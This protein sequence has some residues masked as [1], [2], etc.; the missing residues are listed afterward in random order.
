MS[1][2]ALCITVSGQAG[3]LS[4]IEFESRYGVCADNTYG[5]QQSFY[6]L[7]PGRS[8]TSETR[9]FAAPYGSPAGLNGAGVEIGPG[10]TARIVVQDAP[11]DLKWDGPG[12]AF[13]RA[14]AGAMGRNELAL[15]KLPDAWAARINAAADGRTSGFSVPVAMPGLSSALKFHFPEPAQPPPT[16]RSPAPVAPPAAPYRAPPPVTSIAPAP[17]GPAVT[18]PA[19]ATPAAGALT[20]GARYVVD[21]VTRLSNEFAA[22]KISPAEYRRKLAA[23]S[24]MGGY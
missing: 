17:V 18:T 23:L 14:T 11:P 21:G 5:A 16:V 15:P 19:P 10:L 24:N 2:F 22:G 4:F 9:V 1:R 8:P 3:R 12:L 13:A 7:E 20:P 6:A